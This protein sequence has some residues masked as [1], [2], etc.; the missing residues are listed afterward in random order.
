MI[1]L[2]DLNAKVD[3]NK[4]LLIYMMENGLGDRI[5]NYG[6]F[7]DFLVIGDITY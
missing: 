2:S 1:V 7:V 6:R 5:E 3:S 4:T